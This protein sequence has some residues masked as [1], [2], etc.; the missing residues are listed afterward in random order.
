MSFGILALAF[1]LAA[2]GGDET[3]QEEAV[4]APEESAPAEQDLN[5]I[6]DTENIPDVIATV[7][8]EDIEKEVYVSY[9][10]QQATQMM[11]QGIDLNSEEGRSYL[12]MIEE[13]TL[14]QLVNEKLI[15]Q[16][17]NEANL[18]VTEEE[19][20]QEIASILTEFQLESEEELQELIEQQ[21]VTMDELRDDVVEYVKRDKYIQQ[22]I[23]VTDITEEEL[24]AAYDE[25]LTM[26]E[27]ES[28]VPE[29][30]D[31]REELESS[32][33]KEQE[34]AQTA[35]LLEELREDGEVTIHI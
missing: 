8:G 13:S 29:F 5:S 25:L 19:I 7:N 14:Q 9:L 11:M 22:N 21:G 27:D 20:E 4:A 31:Y 15:V 10:Q 34:Q 28:E 33:L 24:Q 17:A 16:A 35:Q 23:N 12:E 6:I 3:E 30:E 18:E 2:C 26:V 32:L 1:G